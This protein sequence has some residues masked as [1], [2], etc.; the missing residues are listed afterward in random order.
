[1]TTTKVMTAATDMKTTTPIH[2]NDSLEPRLFSPFANLAVDRPWYALVTCLP[3]IICTID[4]RWS[5]CTSINIKPKQAII[6]A[7][8]SVT[9]CRED[10]G[11]SGSKHSFL[12]CVASQDNIYLPS[13]YRKVV[14]MP[15]CGIL[16]LTVENKRPF[17][18]NVR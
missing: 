6:H 11:T 1:M 9:F 8:R 12:A 15:I 7:L 10:P 5:A 14:V 2:A 3:K 17:A 13:K 18:R 4:H 16:C